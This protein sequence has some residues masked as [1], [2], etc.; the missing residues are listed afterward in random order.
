MP[1]I[2]SVK[3][4]FWQDEKLAALTVI[5]RLVFLGLISMADDAGRVLDSVKIID[6]FIFPFSD[7]TCADSLGALES[8]ARIARGRTESGQRVLQIV[9]WDRHQKVD[10]PNL[11]SC[12]PKIV[13]PKGLDASSRAVRDNGESNSRV[14]LRP[15]TYDLRPTTSERPARAREA[16]APSKPEL[17]VLK[18]LTHDG[19]T[20]Y[21][22]LARESRSPMAMAAELVA[23]VEGERN[24]R[25]LPTWAGVSLALQDLVLNREPPK[26][27]LLRT[28]VARAMRTLTVGVEA[29]GNGAGEWVP[30]E[31]RPGTPEYRRAHPDA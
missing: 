24:I 27:I 16:D 4:E 13:E 29:G 2:R 21:E 5:D 22:I 19:L 31:E 23:M 14:D 6:A 30:P 1:R 9:N 12:L 26:A 20:A 17:L 18:S 11:K 15:T 3:P 8:L 7:D 10:H 28:Y 25:P